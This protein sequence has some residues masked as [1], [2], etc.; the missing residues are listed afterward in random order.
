MIMQICTTT[1]RL[2]KLATESQTLI[3]HSQRVCRRLIHNTGVSLG[4]KYQSSEL[5]NCPF[6]SEQIWLQITRSVKSLDRVNNQEAGG[7]YSV[8]K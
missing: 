5:S 7:W 8:V 4:L 2:Y 3:T 1:C 6:V